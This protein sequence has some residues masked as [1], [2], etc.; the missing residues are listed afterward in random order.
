ML[1]KLYSTMR[2]DEGF[3]LL[4]LLV[5]VIVIGVLAAIALP[6]FLTQQAAA[7][8]ASAQSDVRNTVAQVVAFEG[9]NKDK[10]EPTAADYVAAGGKLVVSPHGH[11]GLHMSD[12]DGTYTVCGYND[13]G[14][15][16]KS[17]TAAWQFNSATGRSQATT[18]CPDA[19]DGS[20]TVTDP[21]TNPDPTPSPTCSD[22]DNGSTGSSDPS[23]ATPSPTPTPTPDTCPATDDSQVTLTQP[24]KQLDELPPVYLSSTRLHGDTGR[25]ANAQQASDMQTVGNW[26]ATY[27]AK[28]PGA[29]DNSYVD[30]MASEAYYGS[31]QIHVYFYNK[32][33][34]PSASGHEVQAYDYND[35]YSW[36]VYMDP[37]NAQH[38][39]SEWDNDQNPVNS[40]TKNGMNVES[41]PAIMNTNGNQTT[42]YLHVVTGAGNWTEYTP[43]CG[44]SQDLTIPTPDTVPTNDTHPTGSEVATAYNT[45]YNRGYDEYF[46]GTQGQFSTL[47]APIRSTAVPLVNGVTPTSDANGT[48]FSGNVTNVVIKDKDG[49]V[50]TTGDL[51]GSCTFSITVFSRDAA[52]AEYNRND[53]TADVYTNQFKCHATWKADQP[54]DVDGPTTSGLHSHS[55]KDA[56]LSFTD[57]NGATDTLPMQNLGVT[58]SVM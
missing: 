40:S 55:M 30:S 53:F 37:S 20:G 13:N 27:T 34:H 3:T 39:T 21:T 24:T 10:V 22:S 54:A 5:V 44:K 56:T 52:A 35:G 38:F 25:V 41:R 14:G 36:Y 33:D 31:T 26:M 12:T 32:S 7:Y 45:F 17:A 50:L 58:P 9:L 4:E 1:S 2:R 18:S 46:L 42:G 43:E 23:C 28:H 47:G 6:V 11:V 8:D 15:K 19:S 16:Y 29:V 48:T 49:N 57:W 51:T